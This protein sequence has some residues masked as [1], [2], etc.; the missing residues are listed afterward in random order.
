M[1]IKRTVELVV[2]SSGAVKGTDALDDSMTNLNA[3]F[4]DVNGEVQTVSDRISQL[5]DR[6]FSLADQGKTNTKE[7]E[8]LAKEAGRLKTVVEETDKVI[9]SLTGTFSQKFG[10]AITG[11]TGAF[12][13]GTGVMGAFGTESENVQ[14]LLLR[15]QSAMAIA[16]GIERIKEA[17]G[18]FG[19]LTR[20]ILK[21]R[22]GQIALNVAQAAGAIGMK[23]LNAVMNANP[24]FLIIAGITALVGALAFFFSATEKAEKV[25]EK[26]N[27]SHERQITLINRITALNTKQAQ[28]RL[29]LLQAQSASEDELHQQRLQI[30]LT[31]E[32]AR[33]VNL[34][35]ELKLIADKRKVLKQAIKEGDKEIIKSIKEELEGSRNR[36]RD[37]ITQNGDFKQAIQ[38]ENLEFAKIQ[39]EARQKEIDDE[40]SSFDERLEKFKA[41][42][43]NRVDATRRIE[44]LNL[45]LLEEGL[46]K[47]LAVNKR[48]FDRI[49]E[50]T[51][52][53]EKLNQEE[54][55][56]IIEANN[57][58]RQEKELALIQ[59]NTQKLR[60]VEDQE[61]QEQM[62]RED[63]QFALME[64][65]RSTEREKEIAAIVS[66][67]ETKFELSQGNA[68]LELELHEAQ[69]VA[70]KE[71]DDRF[72][73]EAAA[74]EAEEAEKSKALQQSVVSARVEIAK[75]GFTL[76]SD[77]ATLFTGKNER[78]QKR[79]FQINK[80]AGIATA[81]ID[82]VTSAQAAYRSQL[83]VPT[84]DAPIRAGLAAAFAA[85]QGA[86]RIAAIARTKFGSASSVPTGGGGGGPSIGQPSGEPSEPS[87]SVVGANLP[88]Q[89]AESLSQQ[90]PI[91]VQ[92]V[93][94]KVTTAQA[95][96]R[97]KIENASLG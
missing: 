51:K 45:A 12:E 68:E 56:K 79:A 26:L 88:N 70:I 80:A 46:E 89:L 13:I 2:D 14:K 44:D 7:F 31:E 50:A 29:E 39:D 94:G 77:L 61:F 25:N 58:L 30:L 92:V 60:D 36:Y 11:V 35:V 65:L 57:K 76:L 16:D 93:A 62:V 4:E 72:E 34:K 95:L 40:Q 27:K 1:A 96:E 28:Q 5:E 18:V 20:A 73:Q 64:E 83:S 38:L 43:Q 48:N 78:A 32:A 87:F 86:I 97:N 21:T 59:S 69:K 22:V 66:D 81:T 8:D 91:E 71:I 23:I 10:K 24:V 63:E 54:K 33:K 85:A 53:D 19:G 52:R 90:P 6:M 15:V 41:F 84:P 55:T 3:T 49:I 17:Q 47:E 74:K 9:D 37:L 67:F 82:T 75:S 42:Q